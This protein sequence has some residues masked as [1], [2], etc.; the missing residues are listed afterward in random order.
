MA[1]Q[2]E[3]IVRR[4][5]EAFNK[6]NLSLIEELF[7]N[8]YVWHG[9]ELEVRG[10]DGLR[11]LASM[12]L[13]AFPDIV[14]HIDELIEAGDKVVTRWNCRATHRG[15]LM[16]VAP[17][18][19]TINI[20]GIVISRIAN[21]KIAEDWEQFDQFNMFKQVGA[22]TLAQARAAISAFIY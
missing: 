20:G 19:K 3:A 10:R 22:L 18:G 6:K 11:Q 16:S 15:E 1:G 12:Y 17:T 5:V 8:D 13:G 4:W 14:I 7:T 21:G 2:G 9:P